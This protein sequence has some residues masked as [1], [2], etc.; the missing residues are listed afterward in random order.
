MCLWPDHFTAST[1]GLLGILCSSRHRHTVTKT[2]PLP[3]LDLPS[4]SATG[5]DSPKSQGRGDLPACKFL[6]DKAWNA[7][8]LL[9]KR[10]SFPLNA[11]AC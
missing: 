8:C 7:T 10:A 4:F 3:F 5:L 9:D 1:Q 2:L 6:K 11:S